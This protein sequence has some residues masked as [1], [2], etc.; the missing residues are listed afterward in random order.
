MP[1]SSLLN[2]HEEMTFTGCAL[3][4]HPVLFVHTISPSFF[5]AGVVGYRRGLEQLNFN[6][7]PEHLADGKSNREQ[8]RMCFEASEKENWQPIFD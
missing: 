2:D 3:K 6:E 4:A 1:P 7:L 5:R 8:I